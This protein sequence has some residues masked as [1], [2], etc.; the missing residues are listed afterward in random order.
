MENKH[1]L[2]QSGLPD[3]QNKCNISTPGVSKNMQYLAGKRLVQENG[4]SS[5]ITRVSGIKGLLDPGSMK[6][7]DFITQ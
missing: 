2:I 7:Q 1:S 5:C 6:A 4:N 3:V